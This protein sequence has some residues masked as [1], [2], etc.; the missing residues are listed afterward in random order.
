MPSVLTRMR[1]RIWRLVNSPT[2][3]TTSF[4]PTITPDG[5]AAAVV[6]VDPAAWLPVGVLSSDIGT[7]FDQLRC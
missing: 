3:I 2:A 4:S 6:S 7:P 5:R 1:S